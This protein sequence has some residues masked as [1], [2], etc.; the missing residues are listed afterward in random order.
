MKK[1]IKVFTVLVLAAA[2][3]C[4]G[5]YFYNDRQFVVPEFVEK[6]DIP[7][8]LDIEGKI[9][10]LRNVE[11]LKFLFPEEEKGE[12]VYVTAVETLM[13]VSSGIQN[14][15][16]GV[17]EAQETVEVSIDNN[18]KV[19]EVKVKVGQ[20][21][22]K[23]EL[24]FEYD[25]T[26][27]QTSLQEA[28]LDLDRL[29]NEA[30]SYADQIGT[31][32]REKSRAK[33]DAQLSYT[34]E[35]ETQRMNLKKNEYDQKSKAAEIEQLQK[36]TQNT[37]VRSDINGIIQKIDNT[38]L[39]S[40]G[41]SNISDTLSDDS[42]SSYSGTDSNSNA[43]ITILSTGAYRIKGMTNEL[44]INNIESSMGSPVIIRS[45]IDEN[46][47]W[48]GV[49]GAVDREN[50][51]NQ[52]SN[53]FY[54]GNSGDLTTT[55]SSYPFYVVLDSSEGLMLGQHVFIEIDEGQEEVKK[56]VWLYDFY[57]VDP[58][59]ENPYVWAVNTRTKRLEKRYITLGEHDE[60]LMEYQITEGLENE[61]YIAYP[62]DSLKEGSRTVVG[63]REEM[64]ESMM[65]AQ[66]LD[67]ADDE[68]AVEDIGGDIIVDDGIIEDF[69][70][71][72][73]IVYEE[74]E[75]ILGEDG[76]TFVEG[77]EVLEEGEELGEDS[78]T[79][80]YDENGNEIS[81]EEFFA[82]MEVIED[83][84]EGEDLYF[85]EDGNQITEEEFF[86]SM[87]EI[88]ELEEEEAVYYDENGNEISEEEFFSDLT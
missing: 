85:D 64:M 39:S 83:E 40:S 72:E 71:A 6:W 68:G 78:E 63:P 45:R 26:S 65:S 35:I 47:T 21:V 5:W 43:F 2:A 76:E 22:Q 84:S 10:Y 88:P 49:M 30:V 46:K 61:D 51:S 60:E 56:G 24:L 19:S 13:G 12:S 18:R 50:S 69:S 79:I 17:V 15:F 31:L 34:V 14:R 4:T 33:A 53:S 58:E 57:I 32:E 9:E 82:D 27:L 87:E 37:E 28:Q 23:G 41:D 54:D 20:E 75:E 42:F 55:S 74:G 86:A 29:K 70:E 1:G 44:N 16:A 62:A 38:K 59:G 48:Y 77:E 66:S 80:Y 36:A 67:S 8:K 11:F 7:G 52:S 25:L 3:G 73:G 81:E